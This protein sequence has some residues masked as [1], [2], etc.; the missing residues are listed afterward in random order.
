MRL[1]NPYEMQDIKS[2]RH[3][4]RIT[5]RLLRREFKS[6]G[7]E[8][9]IRFH[10]RVGRCCSKFTGLMHFQLKFLSGL[11]EICAFLQ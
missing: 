2:I 4:N 7:A 5:V 1:G 6:S 3:L 9:R 10:L 8:L 11:L